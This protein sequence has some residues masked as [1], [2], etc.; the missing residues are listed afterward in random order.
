M[1]TGSWSVAFDWLKLPN[2]IRSHRVYFWGLLLDLVPSFAEI[3]FWN[4]DD[5]HPS[6]GV[7]AFASEAQDPNGD[8]SALR[9]VTQ[10]EWHSKNSQAVNWGFHRA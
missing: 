1:Q 4:S 3:I 9:T 7:N 2:M 5:P 6:L 10:L 8:P